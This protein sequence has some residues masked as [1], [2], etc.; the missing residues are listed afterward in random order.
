MMAMM[1]KREEEGA[2]SAWLESDPSPSWTAWQGESAIG[3]QPPL[4]PVEQQAR[5]NQMAQPQLEAVQQTLTTMK[6]NTGGDWMA[7]I[8]RFE[9]VVRVSRLSDDDALR[10]LPT[11]LYDRALMAFFMI[12]ENQRATIQQGCEGMADV[13]CPPSSKRQR[14]SARRRGESEPLIPC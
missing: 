13:F 4:P 9:A 2:G 6:K 3:Q 7:F 12:P 11:V 10:V 14:F 5:T 1:K 8:K